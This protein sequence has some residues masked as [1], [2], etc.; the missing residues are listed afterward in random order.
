[1]QRDPKR[2]YY[3]NLENWKTRRKDKKTELYWINY[4]KKH[5]K[6]NNYEEYQKEWNFRETDYDHQPSN[7]GLDLMNP[8]FAY[9]KKLLKYM[10][11]KSCLIVDG[12]CTDIRYEDLD[13]YK[14][15][16]RET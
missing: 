4:E 2:T 11:I 8:G 6:L 9:D 14:E 10:R 7:N 12:Q 13:Y 15:P 1:M 16:N 5:G 3:T